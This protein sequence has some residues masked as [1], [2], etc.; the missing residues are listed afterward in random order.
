MLTT[1]LCSR[2]AGGGKGPLISPEVNFLKE[3]ECL[4]G[5]T[6]HIRSFLYEIWQFW[7]AYHNSSGFRSELV[8]QSTLIALL[9]N[10]V[11]STV[12]AWLWI[13]VGKRPKT[14]PDCARRGVELTDVSFA[15]EVLRAQDRSHRRVSPVFWS[16]NGSRR[17]G[18]GRPPHDHHTWPQELSIQW[19]NATNWKVF[20]FKSVVLSPRQQFL[21][22]RAPGSDWVTRCALIEGGPSF[23][24][25]QTAT[26][27]VEIQLDDEK[28]SCAVMCNRV[29]DLL[30]FGFGW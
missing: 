3:K 6:L 27:S 14:V 28:R 7:V 21:E 16:D 12:T 5:A 19:R 8:F 15:H 20:G 25:I 10:A 13:S 4:I 2:K 23:R 24:S 18:L 9:F 22:R 11:V 26:R 1:A 30:R 17:S 29:S